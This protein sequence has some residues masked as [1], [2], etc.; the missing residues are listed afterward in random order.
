MLMKNYQKKGIDF[1]LNSNVTGIGSNSLKFESGEKPHEISADS[2][3][4]SVGR[5]PAIA[6]IGLENIGVETERGSIKTDNRGKTNLPQVYAVGDVNGHFMLAHAAYREAEVCVNNMM[7]G[8]DIMRYDAVP[9]V[10]YT[11]PEVASVG[12]TEETV[13]AS[14][15]DFESA[16]ISMK[17]SGR[18]IAENEGGDGICKILIDKRRKKLIGAHMIGNY[19]SEII[20]G[21]AIMIETEMRV[22]DIREIVFPHPTVSEILRE[23]MFELRF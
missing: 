9:M 11:N 16:K 18:F 23:A 19:S 5:K 7:G 1:R 12:H 13:K 15:I 6:D 4:L 2:V 17:Y 20:F 10:I 14:G 8:K 21:A 3:L 22:K